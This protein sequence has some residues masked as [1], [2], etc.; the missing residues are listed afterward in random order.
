MI[1]VSQLNKT[2]NNGHVALDDVSFEIPS[3]S[4]FGLLGLNGAGK[5]T[6]INILC[7]LVQK[8]S[9]KVYYNVLDSDKDKISIKKIVGIMP[10]EV[11]RN[12]FNTV[13][14]LLHY[15]A[16]Y[17]GLSGPRIKN[18]IDELL[19]TLRL[20]DKRHVECRML[21]GGMM[22]R[23][24]LARALVSEP[25]YLFLDEPTAGVDVDLRRDIYSLLKKVHQRGVTMILTS[26]Y[27]EDIESLCDQVAIIHKG[28]IVKSGPIDSI[29]LGQNTQ[30]SYILTL[31]ENVAQIPEIPGVST[32]K[33]SDRMIEVTM[34]NDN[35]IETLIQSI[36]AAGFHI[37]HISSSKNR[38][39]SYMSQLMQDK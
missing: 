39:E 21:S 18:N 20:E 25:Q 14:E 38:L 4:F 8:T 19:T 23:V 35:R 36:A 3:G 22:R 17:Y 30:P 28:N 29:D 5:S 6:I 15:Q 9:G 1:K 2:Y 7:N 13:S 11:N 33:I 31:K 16:G 32:R 27:M 24:I 12:P 34:H 26:H 37:E 10:Q